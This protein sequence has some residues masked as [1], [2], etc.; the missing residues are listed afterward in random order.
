VPVTSRLAPLLV[1]TVLVVV[2][3]ACGSD[4]PAAPPTDSDAADGTPDTDTTEPSGA[5]EPTPS[6]PAAAPIR[7]LVLT[8]AAGF[9]HDSI[10][11]AAE[12]LGGLGAADGVVA[13]IHTDSS[14]ITPERLAEADVVVFV[15][16]TGDVLDDDEQAAL[17]GWV[18]AGGAW[19]G[20]HGAADAEV[21]WPFWADLV[22][23]RFVAH[24][25][26]QPGEVVVE[27]P[28]HR[29]VEGWPA[30]GSRDEEWYTFDRD[31]SAAD[32]VA[33]TVVVSLDEATVAELPDELRMGEHPLA[34][35][36]AVGDGTSFYTALGHD[37]ATWDDPLFRSHVLGAILAVA[38]R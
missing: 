3:P 11:V 31:P 34:W 26:P 37:P 13:T 36:H 15:S 2:L 14:V 19:V 5:T 8:E 12:W 10:D 6:A 38:G 28:D 9:R 20:I 23:A 30:R 7:A 18:R 21:D 29:S 16:T 27:A 17:E 33:A 32:A 24:P 1:A 25:A 22:G 35:T 4:D